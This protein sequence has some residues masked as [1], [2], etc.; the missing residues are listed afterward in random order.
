MN[1]YFTYD[2]LL[3]TYLKIYFIINVLFIVINEYF[4]TNIHIFFY[5]F[6]NSTK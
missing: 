1:V 2:L 3:T 4:V 6:Y 5:N